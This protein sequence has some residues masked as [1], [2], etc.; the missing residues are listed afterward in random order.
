LE[1]VVTFAKW[2]PHTKVAKGAKGLRDLRKAEDQ[3]IIFAEILVVGQSGIFPFL[4]MSS[5]R[6]A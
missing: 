4:I 6:K 2:M 3:Q 5:S 1:E